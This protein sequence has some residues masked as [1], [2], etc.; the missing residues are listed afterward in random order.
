M[1]QSRRRKTVKA[2]K[3]PKDLSAGNSAPRPAT[4]NQRNLQM[5]VIVV[6]VA[7]LLIGAGYW[8]STRSGGGAE[9]KTPGGVTYVDLVEGTGTT[10][11]RGQMC[12]V[13]YTGSLQK[14]GTVFDSSD[15]HG[16]QPYEFALG[17]GSVIQGWH[18]GIAGMKVGGKRHLIIPAKLGYGAQG[19][20]PN[21]PPNSTLLF[22]VELVSVK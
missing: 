12:A 10:P 2:R 7:L 18:E 15:K 19:S 9:H 3:R 6:A 20:P 11:Q 16:G 14:D 22:D 1:P 5:L 13:K 8:W 21:I 17:T 4:R